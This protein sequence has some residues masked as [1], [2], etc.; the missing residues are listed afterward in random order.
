MEDDGKEYEYERIAS[1]YRERLQ[2]IKMTDR[3]NSFE[4]KSLEENKTFDSIVFPKNEEK[5]ST[6]PTESEEVSFVQYKPAMR[7]DVHAKTHELGEFSSLHRYF[8]YIA[9]SKQKKPEEEAKSLALKWVQCWQKLGYTYRGLLQCVAQAEKRTSEGL[10]APEEL[11]HK[12]WS[13]L[14]KHREQ[15][16]EGVS[17]S[18]VV[19]S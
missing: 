11:P 12:L 13:K 16:P 8:V 3:D 18:F 15:L 9:K 17:V 1:Q 4:E 5:Q 6:T 10:A 7:S 14:N 2:Q 19:V